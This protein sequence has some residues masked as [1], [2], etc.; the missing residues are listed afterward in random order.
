MSNVI[1]PE[2]TDELLR[3]RLKELSGERA[4]VLAKSAPIRE[5]IAK[6]KSQCNHALKSLKANLKDIEQPLSSIDSQM[7]RIA[8]GL[9]GKRLSDSNG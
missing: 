5:E 7:S 2:Y 1:Q 8:R 6:V 4:E 9:P 3:K